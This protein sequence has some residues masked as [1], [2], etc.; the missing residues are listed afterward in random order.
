MYKKIKIETKEQLLKLEVIAEK[1][2]HLCL[3][4]RINLEEKKMF[5]NNTEVDLFDNVIEFFL[6][7]SD[8]LN[9]QINVS[10]VG[11]NLYLSESTMKMFENIVKFYQTEIKEGN[12]SEIQNEI[13]ECKKLLD[14]MI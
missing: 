1:L 8:E 10:S 12:T 2:N 9:M 11:D 7:Y 3:S 6:N 13:N 5:S 14:Y 4:L